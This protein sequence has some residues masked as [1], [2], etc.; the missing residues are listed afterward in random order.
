MVSNAI[1]ALGDIGRQLAEG[2]RSHPYLAAPVLIVVVFAVV[3]I[4]YRNTVALITL[5]ILA[6]I[7]AVA[8]L[9]MGFYLELRS[10]KAK[11]GRYAG[12]R[13]DMNG[14]TID[15]ANRLSNRG[16]DEIVTL[17]QGAAVDVAQSLNLPTERV[18]SNLFGVDDQDQMRML[19]G[20]TFQ[21]D[22]AEELTISMPVGFGSN[23]RC[24]RSG[25]PNIAILQENWGDAVIEDE[26]LKKVHPDLRWI[27]SV[28]V[29]TGADPDRPIWVLNVDGLKERREENDLRIAVTRL[30][31]WSEA[32]L[33][34]VAKE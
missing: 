10:Q 24:F 28:P 7:V 19:P 17:L 23:G 22:R 29:F 18:R 16:R 27:I 33:L 30:L 13:I 12:A 11:I 25:K 21:M 6:V 20:L 9:A 4:A 14:N 32:I 3:A 2:L 31:H 8:M 26:E 1:G 5:L 34:A 15:V